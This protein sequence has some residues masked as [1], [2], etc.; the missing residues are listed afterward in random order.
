MEAKKNSYK[1]SKECIWGESGDYKT[2][3]LFVTEMVTW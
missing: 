1:K 3:I 2:F